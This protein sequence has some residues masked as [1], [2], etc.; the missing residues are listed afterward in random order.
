MNNLNFDNILWKSNC[1]AGKALIAMGIIP[2]VL[3]IA[4]PFSIHFLG[5]SAVPITIFILFLVTMTIYTVYCR[6]HRWINPKL[7]FVLTET[8]VIFTSKNNNSYFYNEYENIADYS[9]VK[10]DEKYTSVTLNFRKPAD[11]GAF[12][13]ILSMT[14][15]KIEN[16]DV[17][18]DILE[19]KE[20]PCIQ[21]PSVRTKFNR[22]KEN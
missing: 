16:F 7:I 19:T 15:A 20:I 2:L 5:F 11:A 9:Y 4:T 14:M 1:N 22:S 17:V 8:G 6:K 21:N 3:L 12:G 13:K 18:Q 10:H